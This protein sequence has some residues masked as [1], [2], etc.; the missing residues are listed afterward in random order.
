MP[1]HLFPSPRPKKVKLY[2]KNHPSFDAEI[3]AIVLEG[4]VFHLGHFT[5]AEVIRAMRIIWPKIHDQLN[6][7]GIR[8]DDPTDDEIREVLHEVDINHTPSGAL[9]K[10]R[11]GWMDGRS[12][13]GEG[14]EGSGGGGCHAI[15]ASAP[16][17]ECKN[18]KGGEAE[19]Q[20]APLP[21]L[22]PPFLF[23]RASWATL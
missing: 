2:I 19:L 1:P 15:P 17:R 3:G 8:V 18:A 12:G 9:E 16:P 4:T 23:S 22:P 6:A 7:E 11:G 13:V 10:A 5:P 21:P 14:S 20:S